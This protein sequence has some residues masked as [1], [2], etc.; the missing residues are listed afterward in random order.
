MH[1]GVLSQSPKKTA[2]NERPAPAAPSEHSDLGCVPAVKA[3]I[4]LPAP[5]GRTLVLG[6]IAFVSSVGLAAWLEVSGSESFTGFLQAEMMIVTADGGSRIQRILVEEGAVVQTGQPLVI[7]ADDHLET[8][9][10]A[11]RRQLAAFESELAQAQAKAEVELTWRL[12]SVESEI[13][14]TRLKSA[15]YLKEQFSRQIE[16]LAWH[17]FLGKE[18]V[19][20]SS[21]LDDD[22]LQR[23]SDRDRL[24]EETRLR[25]MLEREAARNAAEVY[26][27]QVKL[28]EARLAELEK[29]RAEMPAKIRRAMGVERVEA[30]VARATEEV[31]RLE[32]RHGELTVTAPAYG[33][34]GVFRKRAGDTVTGGEPLVQLLDED[35]RFLIVQLPSRNVSRISAGSV[36][37]VRFPNGEKRK[38]KVLRIPPQTTLEDNGPQVAENSDRQ[39][40]IRIEP[41]DKLWPQLPIG[42]AVEIEVR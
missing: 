8:T 30:Q 12:Q 23:L 6:L 19:V 34:V 26:A 41:I 29:L 4:E 5:P 22:L 2:G 33:T 14:E 27:A 18:Q 39:I 37:R 20:M 3:T 15:S 31:T 16:D 1:D 28:C 42:S 7:L 32:A 17:E 9:L 36:V 11:A 25:L 10:T 38:G 24:P 13:F 21:A 35:R 40:P